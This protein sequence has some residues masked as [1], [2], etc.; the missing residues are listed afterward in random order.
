MS[1]YRRIDNPRSFVK[2]RYA[3]LLDG[4]AVGHVSLLDRASWGS[5]SHW[6]A[7]LGDDDV[8]GSGWTRAIAARQAVDKL[9]ASEA[10]R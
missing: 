4:V 3:I 7:V 9:L 6:L 10:V 1:T 5:H 8:A 2:P